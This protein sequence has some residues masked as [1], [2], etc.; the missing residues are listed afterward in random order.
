VVYTAIIIGGGVVGALTARALS[1]YSCSVLLLEKNRDVGSG[2]SKANSGI[3]HA[4]FDA[5]PGT[6]KALFNVRG[7]RMMEGVCKELGVHYKRNGSMVL[8]F[9]EDEH[10]VL[11]GL[12]RQGTENGVGGL[13]IIDGRAARELEPALSEEAQYALLAETGGIVCPYS[14]AA[15]AA[16]SAA[17]N[18]VII[19]RDTA[20][21]SIRK[22]GGVF[23]VGTSAGEYR[24]RYI[25]NAAGLYAGEIAGLAG[26]GGV[27]ITPRRGEYMLF[28]KRIGHIV[29]HTIFQ[30]PSKIYG[31][32]VLV[33]PT[34]ENTLLIGPN[35]ED[36]G[37]GD[38]E[39]TETTDEGQA[40]VW[41][42]ALK[43][44]P[45]ISRSSLITSFAGLRAI[46]EG[47]DFILE[48]S[49]IVPGLVNAAGIQSPGLTASPAI[50][51]YLAGL[52]VEAEGGLSLS[53]TYS[54]ALKERPAILEMSERELNALISKDAAYGNIICRCETV[55]E[56]HIVESMRRE[57]GAADIDGVKRRTRA[58]MGRCQGGFCMPRVLEIIA[59][60]TGREF[61]EITKK[62][63]G[64][65]ILSGRR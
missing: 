37:L 54:P 55:S 43:S 60:E 35:A 33:T 29:S 17:L 19:R 65:Y 15:N 46:A 9:S 63:G 40:D 53:G 26:D 50:A 31:K 62:D 52:I 7:S 44:V 4:G 27:R 47:D 23:T 11:K 8:A 12:L 16:E 61:T 20:V 13:S 56:G 3:A 48:W 25:I 24:G 6:I 41:A 14:L 21:E 32:G 57:C 18:G 58:G 59:R 36:L 22:E 1:K 39:A 49:R 51:E 38:Y 2:A 64:S 5:K 42:R 34:V 28:D 10:E 45:G 30:M